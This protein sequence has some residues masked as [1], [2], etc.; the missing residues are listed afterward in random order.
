[1]AAAVDAA[2]DHLRR[3]HDLHIAAEVLGAVA[4]RLFILHRGRRRDITVDAGFPDASSIAAA[5]TLIRAATGLAGMHKHEAAV[6]AGS[7]AVECDLFVRLDR[8]PDVLRETADRL[9]PRLLL[10]HA[11]RLCAELQAIPAGFRGHGP[12]AA[13]AGSIVTLTLDLLG[14]PGDGGTR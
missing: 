8:T 14:L 10:D 6:P 2:R 11:L 7:E 5:A 4:L 13:G 12:W 9:E 1:M 3:H